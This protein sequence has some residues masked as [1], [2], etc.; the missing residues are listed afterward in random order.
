MAL[1]C[2][3]QEGEL[4]WGIWKIDELLE[5][6]KRTRENAAIHALLVE[7]CGEDKVIAHHKSGKPFLEDGLYHIS[8]SHTKGYAAVILHPSL[9]VGID[10]EQYG[11]K[12]RRVRNKFLQPEEEEHLDVG[13][14]YQLLLYWSAKETVYKALGIDGV[15]LK[16]H[17]RVSP[18]IFAEQGAFKVMELKTKTKRL[19]MLKYLIHKDFVLTY[20][21]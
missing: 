1:F 20:S 15:E 3:H 16:E 9:E 6:D 7:L 14:I 18:F 11:D 12:V 2:K 4:L 8:I 5:S 17:I 10:I 19:F 13:N 21:S